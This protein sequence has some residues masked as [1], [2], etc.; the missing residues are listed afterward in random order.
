[1]KTATFAEYQEA[2]HDIIGGVEF[3]EYTALNGK[4]MSKQYAVANGQFFYEI[5]D[6]GITEFWSSKY[7]ESRKYDD[8]TGN[9]KFFGNDLR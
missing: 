2:K 9:E 6:N 3:K 5:N 4:A 8:R 7:G 1:M